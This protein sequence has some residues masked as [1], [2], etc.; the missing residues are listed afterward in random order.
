MDLR[1]NVT[2]V[3]FQKNVAQSVCCHADSGEIDFWTTEKPC[4]KKCDKDWLIVQ[5]VCL[6]GRTDEASVLII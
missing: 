1:L 5:C 6:L 4:Q 2:Y 3:V